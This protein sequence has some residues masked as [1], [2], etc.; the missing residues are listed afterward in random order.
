MIV[1]VHTAGTNQIRNDVRS[2]DGVGRK[3]SSIHGTANSATTKSPRCFMGASLASFRRPGRRLFNSLIND[4]HAGLQT[5][6][7]GT[8]L[9][10]WAGFWSRARLPTADPLST[11][12][13]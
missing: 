7:F 6:M 5:S 2:P 3:G 11:P 8:G 4:L 10:V 1:G 12:S 13:Q 9:A